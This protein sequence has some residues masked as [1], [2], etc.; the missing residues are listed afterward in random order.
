VTVD[1]LGR[2]ASMHVE[3][4]DVEDYHDVVNALLDGPSVEAECSFQIE[5]SG[6]HS[7]QQIRDK[8]QRFDG[9]FVQDS[10]TAAW[11]AESRTF[12]FVSDPPDTSTNE[13]SVLARERN[14]IYF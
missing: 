4:Q 9:L 1:F 12:E 10:A 14:G 3:H 6:E 8:D 13:F 2:T 7:V 5:L 11:T